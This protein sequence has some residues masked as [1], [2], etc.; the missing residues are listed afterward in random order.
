MLTCRDEEH[1]FGPV[2][3]DQEQDLNNTEL[4]CSQA[5]RSWSQDYKP[6]QPRRIRN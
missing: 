6:G 5:P 1:F 3:Q 2:S 4:E